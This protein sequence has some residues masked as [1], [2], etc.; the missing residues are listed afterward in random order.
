MLTKQMQRFSPQSIYQIQQIGL[1]FFEKIATDSNLAGETQ[2][3][4]QGLLV[5]LDWGVK[6]ID[7]E[8]GIET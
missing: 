4:Y 3:F 5:G 6:L 8:Q 7:Q 1:A 2:D